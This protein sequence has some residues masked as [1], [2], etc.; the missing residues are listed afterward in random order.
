MEGASGLVFRA[1]ESAIFI[2]AVS[3]GNFF[4]SLKFYGKMMGTPFDPLIERVDGWRVLK[5]YG[6]M[7]GTPSDPLKEWMDGEYLRD[8]GTLREWMD[9]ES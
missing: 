5:F 7:M 2:I 4:F 3:L 6:R 9:G 1:F 8:E